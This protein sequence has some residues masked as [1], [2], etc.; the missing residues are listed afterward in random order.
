MVINAVTSMNIRKSGNSSTQQFL[1]KFQDELSKRIPNNGRDE[2]PWRMGCFLHP[3]FKGSTLKFRTSGTAFS[4]AIFD[5][6][7]F[8]IVELVNEIQRREATATL[9]VLNTENELKTPKEKR[10][11]NLDQCLSGSQWEGIE[12]ALETQDLLEFG[13]PSEKTKKTNNIEAQIEVYLNKLPKMIDPDGDILGYWKS[14]EV[15]VPDLARFARSILCIPASSASS[16]RLFSQAGRIITTQRTA[17]SS[18]R[19][20]QLVF[21]HDNYSK[22]A[23]NVKAWD[24]GMKNK[25]N[26][27]RAEKDAEEE[28]EQEEEELNDPEW[29]LS[30][31]DLDCPE[32]DLVESN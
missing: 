4:D 5:Q 23:S 25:N 10:C 17:I 29:E 13:E 19:A 8:R 1:T 2:E 27:S 18:S 3:R 6:T 15:S 14:H 26:E 31:V 11:M 7:Y 16:E 20:E 32:D 21:I 22:I 12:A 28:P 9:D 24:L 30:E